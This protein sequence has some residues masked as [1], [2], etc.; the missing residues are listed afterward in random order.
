MYEQIGSNIRKSYILIALF[1]LLIVALAYLFYEI[2]ELMF[3]L[4]VAVIVA[5]IGSIGGYW[6]SDRIVLSISHA[7][8]ATREEHAFL[9]NSVEGLAL[10]AGIPTPRIYVIEDSAPNAFATGRN[11]DNA[12]ICVTTGLMSKL[13]RLELEGVIGHEMA[14]IKSYDIRLMAVAAVLAG[15][16]ALL[17]DWLLRSLWWG[18]GLSRRRRSIGSPIVLL[19]AILAVLLAPLAATLIRLAV[20]RSREYLADAQGAMLTRY[21]E[22]F[23]SALEK[24]AADI[25]PLEVA[26]KATAHL[27]I[28]NPLKEHGGKLNVLFSTH[29]PIEDRIRRLRKM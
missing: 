12:T 21:P 28:V 4:P 6:Y 22:G 13:N 3:I 27:Y 7:R 1:V 15:T 11:P 29:P 17:A 10:A 9:V 20:S 18:R 24:I 5:A 2:T 26:N 23:A 16:V 14:H 8:P 25:E 19:I